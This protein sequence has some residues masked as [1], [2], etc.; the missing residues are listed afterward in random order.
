MRFMPIYLRSNYGHQNYVIFV[1]AYW[2]TWDSTC[3]DRLVF[4]YLPTAL[5]VFFD[6]FSIVSSETFSTVASIACKEGTARKVSR[7]TILSSSKS[8][9]SEN[10]VAVGWAL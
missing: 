6:H 8:L 5:I 7:E 3:Q 2:E 4:N 9:W 1:E 10:G